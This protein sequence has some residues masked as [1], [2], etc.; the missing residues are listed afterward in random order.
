M[1]HSTPV[2]T[3]A[4]K[5]GAVP[6]RNDF[7]NPGPRVKQALPPIVN[8]SQGRESVMSILPS[9]QQLTAT[10][11]S[12]DLF[13]ES[14]QIAQVY[15]TELR[16]I[17]AR[18]NERI[19][20]RDDSVQ[21]AIRAADNDTRKALEAAQFFREQAAVAKQESEMLTRRATSLEG[22][23]SSL[24]KRIEVL[25]NEL[26][27][28][29]LF[30]YSD[31]ATKTIDPEML[32][33]Q[34]I[35]IRSLIA[36]CN[37]ISAE[38]GFPSTSI[39]DI[40]ESI[41]QQAILATKGDELMVDGIPR[42][43]QSVA[44][45]LTLAECQVLKSLT[46]LQ[47]HLISE[48]Q[49]ALAQE[50]ISTH[51]QMSTDEGEKR[52]GMDDVIRQAMQVTPGLTPAQSSNP[53]DVF[54]HE[55]QGSGVSVAKALVELRHKTASVLL[56][57]TRFE[58]DALLK[59]DGM[60][61]GT[62]RTLVAALQNELHFTR[63]ALDA[64]KNLGISSDILPQ[65][66]NSPTGATPSFSPAEIMSLAESALTSAVDLDLLPLKLASRIDK[67]VEDALV[68]N[69]DYE[70]AKES[71]MSPNV[72][73]R[74]SVSEMQRLITLREKALAELE[75]TAQGFIEEV[76]KAPLSTN[77]DK[78]DLRF[79]MGDSVAHEKTASLLSFAKD[80]AALQT[81][82]LE[83]LDQEHDNFH[84]DLQGITR[85]LQEDQRERFGR[86]GS[87]FLDLLHRHVS[88]LQHARELHRALAARNLTIST[89]Q[90]ALIE[91]Q[92]ACNT[93][94]R[95]TVY[96][97]AVRNGLLKA[98]AEQARRIVV[99][100]L[101]NK[102]LRTF[103]AKANGGQGRSGGSDKEEGDN[104]NTASSQGAETGLDILAVA[105]TDAA[106]TGNVEYA[107]NLAGA[108]STLTQIYRNQI[109]SCKDS[110]REFGKV[111]DSFVSAT[112]QT[113]MAYRVTIET[114][115][116]KLVQ[117]DRRRRTFDM[118]MMTVEQEPDP[119]AIKKK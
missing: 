16:A 116:C 77:F 12:Q 10:I 107:Q 109:A 74:V 23:N 62:L 113:L 68:A 87:G 48:S 115:A 60:D 6:R 32:A 36:D 85:S 61:N 58:Q 81:K 22:D 99:L 84:S 92:D 2:P 59:R 111:L 56:R 46:F 30:F 117:T 42:S 64:A 38:I 57:E 66:E 65:T 101:E 73:D 53:N 103:L 79:E 26:S 80:A 104:E 54:R 24:S 8:G 97:A 29:V 67:L 55:F 37:H 114:K 83:R 88:L 119:G 95:D 105:C 27:N 3:F 40:I 5:P 72:E 112:T 14:S 118:G 50:A 106:L 86:E 90:A 100:S 20:D 110:I 52:S 4:N 94:V 11:N 89:M 28:I 98:Y 15:S 47:K 33:S 108:A 78:D 17:E 70:K 18:L 9:T 19:G 49:K 71:Y 44:L 7:R 75:T 76:T 1:H 82:L 21:L 39:P 102:N 25:N 63:S 45:S 69:S 41:D 96:L 51:T 93:H 91:A 13:D 34:Y 31:A 35:R 43:V